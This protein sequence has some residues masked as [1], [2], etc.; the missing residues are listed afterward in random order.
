MRQVQDWLRQVRALDYTAD[1]DG[2]FFLD[3]LADGEEEVG[4]ELNK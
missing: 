2:A 3:E 1:L 4:G